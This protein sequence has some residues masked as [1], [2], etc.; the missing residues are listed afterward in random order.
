M[1]LGY[2]DIEKPFREPFCKARKPGSVRHRGGDG[3]NSPVL[4][5]AVADKLPEPFGK[6]FPRA[7]VYSAGFY[8]KSRNAVEAFGVFL[9]RD[10]LIIPSYST[11]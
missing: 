6:A 3:D 7:F 2:A 8:I 1:L 9:R 5:G 10:A 4:F 11:S